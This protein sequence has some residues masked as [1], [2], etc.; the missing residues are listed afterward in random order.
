MNREECVLVP[1]GT[2]FWV[3]KERENGDDNVVNSI[4]GIKYSIGLMNG[5]IGV[6]SYTPC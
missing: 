3:E 6:R 1:G 5:W 2:G 4:D